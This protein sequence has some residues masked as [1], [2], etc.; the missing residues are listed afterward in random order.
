MAGTRST[1]SCVCAS[2]DSGLRLTFQVIQHVQGGTWATNARNDSRNN[3]T[4]R[5]S[6]G[7]LPATV[8]S[9]PSGPSPQ[10]LRGTNK[11]TKEGEGRE[12]EGGVRANGNYSRRATQS[13]TPPSTRQTRSAF[14]AF[15]EEPLPYEVTLPVMI[16][17]SP[18]FKGANDNPNDN[19]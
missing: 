2:H 15:C 10:R 9:R 5:D 4:R 14:S 11:Q 18:V 8:R 3:E 19:C 1:T 7:L 6:P 13:L 17:D 16:Q 12:R